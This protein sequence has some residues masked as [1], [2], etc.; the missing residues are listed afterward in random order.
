MLFNFT[1]VSEHDVAGEH[2]MDSTG[3]RYRYEYIFDTHLMDFSYMF[4]AYLH[5]WSLLTTIAC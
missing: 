1:V 3:A 2:N 4:G 5:H